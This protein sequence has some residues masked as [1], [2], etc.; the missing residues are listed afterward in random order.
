MSS[1]NFDALDA[2]LA[3]QPVELNTGTV[4]W[5][6]GTNVYV[7][8][9]GS[10]A[11]T[12]CVADASLNPSPGDRCFVARSKQS[13]MW[14]VLSVYS[15]SRIGTSDSA[16]VVPYASRGANKSSNVSEYSGSLSNV[17][18]V[19]TSYLPLWSMSHRNKTDTICVTLSA[20][21]TYTVSGSGLALFYATIYLDGVDIGINGPMMSTGAITT[22]TPGSFTISRPIKGV[23]IGNHDIT[24]YGKQD[25]VASSRVFTL[26]LADF[27]VYD[28]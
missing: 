23:P 18:A 3:R 14:I 11:P 8:L 12:P 27:L 22:N 4:I 10:Q 28:I 19:S 21:S 9:V 17:T 20:R 5:V 7:K 15:D 25:S 16:N 13:P 2:Y 1:L 6:N 24:I 26:A